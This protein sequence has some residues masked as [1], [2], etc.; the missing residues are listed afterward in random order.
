[1]G[2]LATVAVSLCALFVMYYPEIEEWAV[3]KLDVCN[4]PRACETHGRC[5]T[6]SVWVDDM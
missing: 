1:M 6:H 5:W 2:I 4:P 3:K